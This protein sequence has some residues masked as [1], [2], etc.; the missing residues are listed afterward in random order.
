MQRS[1]ASAL[2]TSWTPDCSCAKRSSVRSQTAAPRPI[3]STAC[4]LPRRSCSPPPMRVDLAAAGSLAAWCAPAAA[5]VAP[6]VAAAFRIPR[7][8]EPPAGI[9][10]TFDD[11]PHPQG[12]PAV[13]HEL[14]RAGACAT[15]FLL[16]GEGERGPVLAAGVAAA[17][18]RV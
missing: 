1:G 6:F 3:R 9:S 5:P 14:E 11:G 16:G 2:P 15:F 13:L 17:G 7:R 8:L 10:I 12:T 4:P 18:H